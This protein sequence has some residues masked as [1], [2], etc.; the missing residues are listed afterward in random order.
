LPLRTHYGTT[1]D[2][3]TKTYHPNASSTLI[4]CTGNSVYYNHSEG[5]YLYKNSLGRSAPNQM[6]ASINDGRR[7]DSGIILQYR[8]N[9]NEGQ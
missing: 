3:K 1:Y 8:Y 7:A 9:Y 6:G 4:D 5:R 2:Q